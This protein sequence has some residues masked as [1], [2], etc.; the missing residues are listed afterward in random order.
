MRA[1]QI[2]QHSDSE[3]NPPLLGGVVHIQYVPYVQ[4]F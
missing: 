3:N 2:Y 1:N 4:V